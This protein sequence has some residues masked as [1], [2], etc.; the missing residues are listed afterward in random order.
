MKRSL[1]ALFG[2]LIMLVL[3]VVPQLAQTGPPELPLKPVPG[4]FKLPP[5][6]NF[7]E[8]AA[9][10]VDSKRNVYV[11][12][13]GGISGPAFGAA[14]GR[15]LEFDTEGKFMREFGKDLY[16][17]SYG[18]G[19]RV[20]RDDNIWIADKGSD[21]VVKIRQDGHVDMVFGRRAEAGDPGGQG[22]PAITRATAL[23]DPPKHEPG[24]FRQPTD[25]A[26]DSEGNLYISDGYIN[27]RIAVYDKN[28][29]WLKSFGQQGKGPGQFVNLH[30]IA[31]DAQDHI[32]IADRANSR[33]QVFDKNFKF[34]YES[35]VLT[36][37][38]WPQT[39]NWWGDI[40]GPPGTD[41]NMRAAPGGPGAPWAL[42]ITPGPTQYLFVGDGFPAR[43]Y[44]MTLDGKVLGMYGG[45][46]RL[47]GQFSWVH[48]LA[49]PSENELYVADENNWRIQQLVKK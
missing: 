15:V 3:A 40:I 43:I 28:G 18:H 11:L 17:A 29:V 5:G 2:V 6:M 36:K 49:C 19:I 10:A 39:P 47:P 20:D 31:I 16:S 45:Q 7:G 23:K 21:T 26:W 9:I 35:N 32:Y 12:D 27:S 8:T 1:L 4:H 33:L 13:R 25:M 44:K 46:G 48:G 30:N 14:S 24:K 38:P 34:L 37:I 42:C 22:P 41:G